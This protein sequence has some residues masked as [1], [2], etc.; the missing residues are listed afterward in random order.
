MGYDVERFVGYVNEGLLCSVCRCV[1]EDAVMSPCEHVFCRVCIGAWLSQHATC[2]ED[3]T[4]L[5][6]T[7]LRPLYRYM[8]NDLMRLQIRCVFHVHGCDVITS[9]E[10][11]DSH[12]AECDYSLLTCSNTGCE[13]RMCRRELEAHL[14]VC[15]FGSR[16][17]LGSDSK[18]SHACINDLRTELHLLRAECVCKVEELRCEMESRLDSQRRHMVQRENLLKNEVEELKAQLSCVM[19]DVCVLLA[20]ERSR[21]QELEKA[22][23]EKAEL[24]ELLKEGQRHTTPPAHTVPATPTADSSPGPRKSGSRSLTLD[25]I[26]RKSKEVTVI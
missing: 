1:C 26:K 20:A 17:S 12:E 10:A 7:Q 5:A 14:S 23:Q 9:L 22:E 24:L 25:C 6:H 2:P 11:L 19:S 15:E 4:H 16:G 21:R 8:R 3:R 13:V 18:D